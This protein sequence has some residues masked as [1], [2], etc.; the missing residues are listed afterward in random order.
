MIYR[1]MHIQTRNAHEIKG[2]WNWIIA[3]VV[4]IF[5]YS[6]VSEWILWLNYRLMVCKIHLLM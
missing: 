3:S 1:K 4:V 2:V 5:Y 6:T